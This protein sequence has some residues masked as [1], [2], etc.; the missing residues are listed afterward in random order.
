MS[1]VWRNSSMSLETKYQSWPY[2]SPTIV[3]W[4]VNV[5]ISVRPCIVTSDLP[6]GQ[7][8]FSSARDSASSASTSALRPPKENPARKR[9]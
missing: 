2:A 5:S 4:Y 3:S 6:L 8:R 7:F 9:G 1:I